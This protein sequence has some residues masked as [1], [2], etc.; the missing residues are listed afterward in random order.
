M[1]VGVP[2]E[3]IKM[4]SNV[5]YDIGE[6]AELHELEILKLLEM[7]KYDQY[8][9]FY[10]RILAIAKSVQVTL[11]D[12]LFKHDYDTFE[13]YINALWEG[14]MKSCPTFKNQNILN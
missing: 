6:K 3:E 14:I 13:I 7:I 2:M 4:I 8:H 9:D 10:N 5:G 1:E 11:P 12:E